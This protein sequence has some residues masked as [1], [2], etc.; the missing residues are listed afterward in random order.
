MTDQIT[1]MSAGAI[2]I[3][4]ARAVAPQATRFYD[5]LAGGFVWSDEFPE[6][7]TREWTVVSHDDLY[8]Y[9]IRIR[10]CITLGDIRMA[11]IPL[12][13]QVVTQA[14]RWPALLPERRSSRIAKRL[15]AAE[16]LAER[17]YDKLFDDERSD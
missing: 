17:C 12:W 6:I 2:A 3:L 9:L 1:T 15:R 7:S 14:P 10:R 11:D 4:D 16:R 13:Q 8:R 5:H